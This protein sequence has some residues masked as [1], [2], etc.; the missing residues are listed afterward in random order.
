MNYLC[1]RCQTPLDRSVAWAGGLCKTWFEC[2]KCN[3]F[4]HTYRPLPHQR[5]VHNDSHKVIGNFGG[6]GTGKTTTSREEIIK[7]ILITPNAFVVV[8]ANILRQYEQTIKRELE[9]DIPK[10]FIANYSVQKQTMDF[11]NGARL[12]WTPFDN[13]DKLRSMNI[14]M[15]VILEASEVKGEAYGQL[16]TRLRNLA[17]GVPL[18]DKNGKPVYKTINGE[19]IPVME[20]DWRKGIIES[21]PDAG[22]IR[23]EVL[24]R[25]HRIYQHGTY[26][27]YQQDEEQVVPSV[28]SHVAATNTNPYLPEGWEDD[29]R[30]KRPEWWVKRYLDGS[31]QYSEGLVYPNAASHIV[32]YFEIPRHW[33]RLIA[34]DY[35]IANVSAM[36]Y[37]AIDEKGGKVYVYRV[38]TAQDRDVEQLAKMYHLG[39]SD[40]PAGGLYTSPII[41]PKSGPK[42]G[43]DLRTLS[44][45]F[46]DYNISF[47]AGAINVDARIYR[48]NTYIES[49][50]LKIMDNC[51]FLINEL[52][53]YRFPDRSLTDTAKNINKPVDKDNHSIN[54]LEWIVMELPSDPRKVVDSLYSTKEVD[55][56]EEKGF[57]TPWQF[58]EN[59]DDLKGGPTWW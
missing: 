11:I 57:T 39:A 1:P 44:E 54:A 52:G 58:T 47:Q 3:T 20:F 7:H 51:S 26:H 59:E 12:L 27:D 50:R 30:R 35:G 28:S 21:N 53:N 49:G 4:L 36:V 19:P 22:W 37:A 40:I 42:R 46:L 2:P 34:F 56:Q 10:A 5:A 14:T 23:N 17:A 15:Y 43:Y 55:R 33:K 41:D 16:D 32:E 38:L 24:L 45:Q 9:A 6:Y 48:L 25:S 18:L 29:L 13:P 31:F 8:G